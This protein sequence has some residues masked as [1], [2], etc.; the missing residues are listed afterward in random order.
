[1]NRNNTTLIG[2]VNKCGNSEIRV[3]TGNYN[4]RDVLD[5]R[6][7]FIP[8]GSNEPVPSRKGLTI[9]VNKAKELVAVLNKV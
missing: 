4:G 6:L 3:T 5:I 2:S 7:W 9:D 8:R 1:M